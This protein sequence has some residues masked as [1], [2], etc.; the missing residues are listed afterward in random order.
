MN[1]IDK[2]HAFVYE[3]KTGQFYMI[4]VDQQGNVKFAAPVSMESIS[5]RLNNL[6]EVENWEMPLDIINSRKWWNEIASRRG[7]RLVYCRRPLWENMT[8]TT[9]RFFAGVSP[10]FEDLSASYVGKNAI[11]MIGSIK[12]KEL[13]RCIM[14]HLQSNFG[15][16]NLGTTL[17]PQLVKFKKPDDFIHLLSTIREIKGDCQDFCRVV[18]IGCEVVSV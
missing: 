1:M 15:A 18:I 4:V 7:T 10:S 8:D 3:S 17:F 12:N 2:L 14:A 11:V 16:V 5:F 13:R 6:Q 9:R